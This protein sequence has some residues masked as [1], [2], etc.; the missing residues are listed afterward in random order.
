MPRDYIATGKWPAGPLKPKAPK[1]AHLAR[2]IAIRFL[3]YRDANGTNINEIARLTGL[4]RQTLY[5]LRHGKSWPNLITVARLETHF[6]R[7]LWGREHIPQSQTPRDHLAEGE[8][9]PDG[10]LDDNAPKEAR[11]ARGIATAILH[12]ITRKKTSPDVVAAK[13]RIDPDTLQGL[14]DGSRWPDFFTVAR[15]EIHFNRRLWG[16]EHKPPRHKPPPASG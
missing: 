5:N 9:W 1:E 10:D 11:L 4:G 2:G 12:Q 7:R 3:H 8:Q 13:R 14:L 6:D 15:L 16:H